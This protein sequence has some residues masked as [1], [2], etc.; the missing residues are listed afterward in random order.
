MP[1]L[2]LKCRFCYFLH[3]SSAGVGASAPVLPTAPVFG[4]EEEGQTHIRS[5]KTKILR[6]GQRTYA[7]KKPATVTAKR[8]L[9]RAPSGEQRARKGNR[10]PCKGNQGRC[11]KNWAPS[12]AR[13]TFSLHPFLS[14]FSNLT[15]M[16]A[17]LIIGKL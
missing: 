1:I 15:E 4:E 10:W 16:V 2:T 12:I 13:N 11:N 8:Q 6:G 17:I 7:I 9:K 5:A 14:R 3:S